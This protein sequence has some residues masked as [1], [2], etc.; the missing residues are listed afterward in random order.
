[1]E[2]I[3]YYGLPGSGKSTMAEEAYGNNPRYLIVNRDDIRKELFG[4]EYLGQRPVREKEQQVTEVQEAIVH[5]AFQNGV[6]VVSSDTNLTPHFDN[7]TPIARKYGASVSTVPVNTPVEV[8]KERNRKRAEQGGHFVPEEVID[9]MASQ[10][11]GEDGNIIPI[12][13]QSGKLYRTPKETPGQ[14]YLQE[15]SKRL[16]EKYPMGKKVVL[17]DVD[18]TLIDNRRE[19]NRA[20]HDPKKKDFDYFF[21]AVRHGKVNEDVVE[22]ANNLRDKE[23]MSI[24]VLT[25]RGDKNAKDLA[26]VIERSGLKASRII[27]KPHGD[28]RPDK[29]FKREILE[30]LKKEGLDLAHSIDDRPQSVE[31][32]ESMNIPVSKVEPHEPMDPV[33]AGDINPRLT[34]DTPFPQYTSAPKPKKP[35]VFFGSD[36]MDPS[37]SKW[38]LSPD[39]VPRRCSATK[40]PCRYKQTPHATNPEAL[41]EYANGNSATTAISKKPVA[42]ARP[43]EATSGKLTGARVSRRKGYYGISVPNEVVEEAHAQLKDHLGEEKHRKLFANKKK[44]DGDEHHMTVIGPLAL[45]KIEKEGLDYG[46]IMDKQYDLEVQGIGSVSNGENTAYYAVVSSPELKKTSNDLGLPNQDFHITLA[47]DGADVHGVSK[48]PET[49]I[50]KDS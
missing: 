13:Y 33:L 11:Y 10:A 44:R 47:F 31:V 6:S 9:R 42:T 39:G 22:L 5:K 48:G 2:L 41:L 4:A 21:Y 14:K 18:G 3:V 40:E 34:I 36:G 7:L 17:V 26:E 16:S 37:A 43:L 8:C 29:L 25:G 1:M 38:H 24:V 23:N 50:R 15:V 19:A 32:Y 30:G 28:F 12:T 49:M 20:F 45:S 46:A 35:K 27:A